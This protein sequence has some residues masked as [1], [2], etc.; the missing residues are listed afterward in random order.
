MINTADN[1]TVITTEKIA[2]NWDYS[3][4]APTPDIIRLKTQITDACLTTRDLVTWLR[5]HQGLLTARHQSLLII[6]RLARVEK[7]Q[8]TTTNFPAQFSP[9]GQKC[10]WANVTMF[11]TMVNAAHSTSVIERLHN[12]R[13][14]GCWSD[15]VHTID[16][17]TIELHVIDSKANKTSRGR[18]TRLVCHVRCAAHLQKC[19][20]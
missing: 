7:K 12:I 4:V 16:V 9:S 2:V 11:L 18:T 8:R 15:R 14:E 19:L 10:S 3:R 13:R 5:Y 17:R 6:D 1:K 20:E